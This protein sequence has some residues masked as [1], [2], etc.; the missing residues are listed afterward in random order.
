M[1]NDKDV[2]NDSDQ[3]DEN[4]E[5]K[6]VNNDAASADD[7]A[8]DNAKNNGERNPGRRGFIIGAAAVAILALPL[9]AG[10]GYLWSHES[11]ERAAN[12]QLSSI[13]SAYGEIQ[14]VNTDLKVFSGQSVNGANVEQKSLVGGSNNQAEES[15]VFIFSNG[16]DSD[17]KKIVDIYLDFDSQ[18]SRDFMLINQISLQSMV[19][20][21]LIELRVHPI[22]SGTPMSIYGSE[23]VAESFYSDPDTS[24]NLLISMMKLSGE[25]ESDAQDDADL[26]VEAIMEKVDELQVSEITSSSIKNGTF[27]SW[28]LQ[29]GNDEK[30]QTGYY[31]PVAYVND[32]E[33]DPD[34]TDFNDVDDFQ[35]RILEAE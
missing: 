34:M 20:N 14:P 16:K 12:S 22:A 17:E 33:I 15:A 23:V 21:G 24:W 25:L 26:V 1:N 30:L 6:A 7:D 11:A 4:D 28:I 13:T 32:V 10:A 3:V 5:R 27:A 29:V 9:G 19:E 2:S 8:L 18:R 31:P 35:K